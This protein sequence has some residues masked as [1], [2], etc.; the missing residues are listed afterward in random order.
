M[1]QKAS[2]KPVEIVENR[3]QNGTKVVEKHAFLL[4]LRVIR[5]R[6]V[7]EFPERCKKRSPQLCE[8]FK[9]D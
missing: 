2:S 3:V 6:N 9:L 5:R 4:L 7:R 8:Q 1:Q